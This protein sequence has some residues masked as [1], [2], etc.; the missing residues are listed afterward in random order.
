MEVVLTTQTA[1]T[2]GD[3]AV[4]LALNASVFEAIMIDEYNG[5]E[6]LEKL[7]AY[8]SKIED[9]IRSASKDR[10]ADL[11]GDEAALTL[12]ARVV[13]TVAEKRKELQRLLEDLKKAQTPHARH[14]L[15]DQAVMA[16][17]YL[18]AVHKCIQT[19]VI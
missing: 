3:W 11:L 16:A 5:K 8:A 10:S 14:A 18:E 1:N 9:S 4:T 7:E 6:G 2:S 12:H 17:A 15:H 13:G 19:C